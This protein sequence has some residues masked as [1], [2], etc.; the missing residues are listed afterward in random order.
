MHDGIDIAASERLI[1]SGSNI[2]QRE[3]CV[4]HREVTVASLIWCQS[5]VGDDASEMGTFVVP[6]LRRRGIALALWR[7]VFRLRKA[8]AM[9]VNVVSQEGDALLGSL[10]REF[11]AVEWQVEREEWLTR[12][13]P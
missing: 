5:R 13:R 2:G 3:L 9:R 1:E 6:K 7:E 11:P 4:V 8:K 10:L 12:D